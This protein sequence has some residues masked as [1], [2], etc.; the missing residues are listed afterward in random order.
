M[1]A[2]TRGEVC[3]K[4]VMTVVAFVVLTGG[5]H[6]ASIVQT[7]SFQFQEANTN[8]GSFQ[9]FNP[10]LGTL[11]GVEISVSAVGTGPEY[12]VF[13]PTDQPITF[14]LTISGAWR[15]DAGA[16]PINSVESMTLPP[17]L[18]GQLFGVG[19]S[20]IDLSA[21]YLSNLGFWIGTGG[22]SPFEYSSQLS[23]GPPLVLQVSADNPNIQLSVDSSF[24]TLIGTETI[25]YL[26]ISSVPE[27]PSSHMLGTAVLILAGAFWSARF[28]A[29]DAGSNR[30][31]GG[32]RHGV[33][34][35]R[36]STLG[37]GTGRGR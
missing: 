10:A 19:S 5:A 37:L 29:G 22:I 32:D 1:I 26:F 7:A 16:V 14:M 33:P 34:C 18:L 8:F 11:T 4:A 36:D 21:T 6:A 35:D 2:Q 24:E 9:Q 12:F 20:A 15:T 27:P 28:L 13:N 30:R 17:N 3:F 31:R 25:T 23:G